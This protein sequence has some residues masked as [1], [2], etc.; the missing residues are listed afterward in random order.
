MRRTASSQTSKYLCLS[1]GTVSEIR[2]ANKRRSAPQIRIPSA[3]PREMYAPS[4]EA[5]S[6]VGPSELGQSFKRLVPLL[7]TDVGV[8]KGLTWRRVAYTL[9]VAAAFALWTAFGNWMRFRYGSTPRPV[10]LADFF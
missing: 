3:Q 2:N 8:L 10:G 6:V 9:L 5:H 1:S 4:P 7:R